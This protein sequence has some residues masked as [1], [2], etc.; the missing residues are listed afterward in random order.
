MSP[1]PDLTGRRLPTFQQ[2]DVE[3][4][5]AAG[6]TGAPRPCRP[7]QGVCVCVCSAHLKTP[8]STNQ[9]FDS[10]CTSQKVLLGLQEIV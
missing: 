7:I 10:I 3:V 6:V 9:R 4:K 5:L 1:G 2:Q 8:H